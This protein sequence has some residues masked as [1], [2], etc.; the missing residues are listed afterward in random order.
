MLQ[1]IER[2]K[3]LSIRK[4]NHDCFISTAKFAK[5]PS[6]DCKVEYAAVGYAAAGNPSDSRCAGARGARG[7]LCAAAPFHPARA[8]P[9]L[10]PGPPRPMPAPIILA[11]PPHHHTHACPHC[12]AALPPQDPRPAHPRVRPGQR[13]AALARQGLP[14]SAPLPSLPYPAACGMAGVKAGEDK[15]TPPHA[16][17]ARRGR[18]TGGGPAAREGCRAGPG[19][20][21]PL[22]EG[23]PPGMTRGLFAAPLPPASLLAI[24]CAGGGSTLARPLIALHRSLPTSVSQKPKKQIMIVFVRMVYAGVHATGGRH[25]FRV[26]RVG[27]A[28][29]TSPCAG[30]V[31]KDPIAGRR[32]SLRCAWRQRSPSG[33]PPALLAALRLP[34]AACAWVQGK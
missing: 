10:H 19:A 22:P 29:S 9:P 33:K 15:R 30:L 7:A 32:S 28:P 20:G 3:F 6:V 17:V 34:A 13:A 21:A 16:S 2:D 8:P 14:Q 1:P 23:A 26:V 5:V 11:P 24:R 31:R 4:M 27:P 18:G 12:A 25:A